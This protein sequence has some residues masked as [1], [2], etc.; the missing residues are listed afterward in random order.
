MENRRIIIAFEK[1]KKDFLL[2]TKQKFLL[3]VKR[4]KI[5]VFLST[6]FQN[7]AHL[8]LQVR[9]LIDAH[10]KYLQVRSLIGAHLYLQVR[11]V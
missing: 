7:D 2:K 1:E 3:I 10:L 8:Y 5:S 11:G 6:I 9:S 4:L